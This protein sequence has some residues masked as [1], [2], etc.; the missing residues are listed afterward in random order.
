MRLLKNNKTEFLD[1]NEYVET[2]ANF[3]TKGEKK[4]VTEK[5]M[6]KKLVLPSFSRI[7]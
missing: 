1:I 5:K 7:L 6:K 4:E 3:L 2:Y